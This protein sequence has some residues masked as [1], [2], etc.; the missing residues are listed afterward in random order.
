M[1]P[2]SQ[3]RP[4]RAARVRYNEDSD[5]LDLS[6]FDT[7]PQPPRAA[8]R[9]IQ[10]YRE[11]SSDDEDTLE[12]S[13]DDSDSLSEE[14][15]PQQGTRSRPRAIHKPSARPQKR[16]T[17][18]A[19]TR[20]VGNPFSAY[21]R[22][23][24]GAHEVS[25]SKPKNAVTI[26]LPPSGRI[27]PWQQL[28]YQILVSIM[29]YAAYPLYESRSRPRASIHW[30][31]SLSVLCRSFHDACTAALLHN[32]PLYPDVRAYGLIHLLQHDQDK[33]MTNYRRKIHYLDI[34]V[35]HLLARK[36]GIALEDLISYTPLLQGMRLYSTY[37]DWRTEVWAQPGVRKIHWSYPPELFDLLDSNNIILKQFEWNGRFPGPTEVLETALAVH[38]RPAFSRLQELSLLNLTAPEKS[39]DVDIASSQSVFTRALEHLTSL[40]RL[41]LT[42]CGYLDESTTPMLPIG[43][44]YLEIDNC[45]ELTSAALERYLQVGGS[46]IRTLKLCDNQ[47]MSLGFM[48]DLNTMCPRLQDIDVDML[49]VDPTSYRDRDPL[50]DELLPNGPPT[51]P[52]SLVNV[53]FENMRQ[54]SA[55][56]AEDFF[57]SLVESSRHLPHLK[58]LNIKAILK[59]A[60]WRDRAQ[61]RKIWLPKLQNVF[62]NRSKPSAPGPVAIA[63]GS[64]TKRPTPS[65]RQSSRIAESL[66]RMSTGD[67]TGDSDDTSSLA[68]QGRCDV[69]NLQ[70]SDQR[71]AQD[72]FREDD[73]L[74][75]E[76]S[77]DDEWMGVDREPVLTGY[78]W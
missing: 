73:F 53:S 74:D 25:H 54:L 30:L 9:R 72:Q 8:R 71:P 45:A 36:S 48:A 3:S 6:D 16:R 14:V 10:T 57:D 29:K 67:D 42:S 7:R 56:D 26:S 11:K 27:P 1:A 64:H 50:Y 32:P 49:Y 76:P 65:Q 38:S 19:G 66:K 40:K 2:S 34:E 24:T 39:S 68:I 12:S 63:A 55:E 43:L 17:Q 58:R 60:S 15:L 59:N 44:E 70:I 35:K 22:Q 78:A 33:L 62:L 28:P 52:S 41:S 4:R 23:K 5:S 47:S 75:D 46:T 61:L 37:D 77:D 20:A 18:V 51:W 13:S 69:V 21:K 31:C